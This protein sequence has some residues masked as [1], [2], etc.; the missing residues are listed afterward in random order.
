M[1]QSLLTLELA[2]RSKRNWKKKRRGG[3]VALE[4][5]IKEFFLEPWEEVC[6][7]SDKLGRILIDNVQT[8]SHTT[9]P[10]THTL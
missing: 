8:G 1:L 10:P 3:S 9:P 6:L 2:G 5:I 4:G 7:L